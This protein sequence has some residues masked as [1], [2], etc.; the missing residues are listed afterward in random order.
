MSDTEKTKQK[1][2]IEDEEVVEEE[3]EPAEKTVADTEST[4]TSESNEEETLE[5]APSD[6][7]S[8][9][10]EEREPELSPEEAMQQQLDEAR[11]QML[12]TRADFD[13]YRKRMARE[14]ERVRKTAAELLIRDLL[15]GI[16]NLDLA[17]QH[18]DDKSAGLAQGVEMVYKQIQDALGGHGLTPIDALGQP[19]DPKVHEAVSQVPSEEYPKDH[20]AQVFQTGYTLGDVVLRPSKVVVSTGAPEESTES[21]KETTTEQS[22]S[23]E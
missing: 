11:D 13:N 15:P 20:V 1:I 4:D 22:A 19:F 16:D 3:T 7:E 2:E 8:E 21:E 12:R 9:E 6:N 5:S 23:A 14:M 10:E 17:L 18:A